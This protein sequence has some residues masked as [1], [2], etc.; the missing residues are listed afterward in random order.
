MA[1]DS[2]VNRNDYVGNGSTAG[3]SFTFKIFDSSHLL[4]SIR[5]TSDNEEFTLTIGTDYTV[6]GVG[7]ESGGS[8]SLVDSNQEWLD[9][10]GFLAT[11][12]VLS[13]RR[14]LPIEQATDIR[15]QDNYYPE[16]IEDQFDKVVMIDQQQQ[17]EID[18]CLKTSETDSGAIGPLPAVED[19]ASK[20][21]G[22]DADGD[23]IAIDAVTTGVAATA[24]AQT[25]LDDTTAAQA[26]ATLGVT[27]ENVSTMIWGGTS[28]GSANAQTL[29]PSPA[30]ASYTNGLRIAFL[31]GSTNS[32]AMTVNVSG[33]GAK[34]VKTKSGANP[35]SGDITSGRVYQLIYDGTNLVCVDLG[36]AEDGA[37]TPAKTSSA[38]SG[39]LVPT[40]M[41]TPFAGSAAPT[42]WLLCDGSAVSRTTYAALFA[43][44]ASAY[45][46][47]D[48]STT[49]NVPDL[50]GM[51]I[52]GLMDVANVTGSGSAASNNATFT[53]HGYKRTGTRVRLSSG[54]LTGLSTATDY[55]VIVVDA[56]TLAFSV[57]KANALAGTKIA[58]SGANSAVIMQWEDPDASSRTSL[59]TGGNSG[60]LT[61]SHQTDGFKAHTHLHARNLGN[62]GTVGGGGQS[63]TTDQDTATSSTGGNDTRPSNIS[64]I[65]II[66]T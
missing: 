6:S 9:S 41:T 52:R 55:F 29:T 30:I 59:N 53:A 50:K 47:G 49:F 60:A 4:V 24:Y 2:T 45:G 43:V 35:V 22:F 56:N 63:I 66:K 57:S 23:P 28:G 15:N 21:L 40:G 3:Y 34:N 27:A 62:P 12:Y 19:R 42:G 37:I 48:G 26:R 1:I 5:D 14:L 33:L 16:V 58:I 39:F 51:F 18:R 10:S 65:Y 25:L 46:S 64:M 54:T 13:I 32:G 31:A 38:I 8:I 11:G 20:T 44:I 61:G 17:D 7:A 36:T